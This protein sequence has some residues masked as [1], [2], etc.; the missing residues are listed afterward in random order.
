[1]DN[2]WKNGLLYVS[3]TVGKNSVEYSLTEP[4]QLVSRFVSL[5]REECKQEKTKMYFN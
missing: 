2:L 4:M 5:H 3:S 1:M